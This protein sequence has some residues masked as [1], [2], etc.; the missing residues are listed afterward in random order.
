MRG[1]G[2]E[3]IIEDMEVDKEST[4]SEGVRLPKVRWQYQRLLRF[5]FGLVVAL[6]AFSM[7]Q[8]HRIQST[9]SNE[10]LEIYHRH[11]RQD[12]LLTRLRRTLWLG[13]NGTRDY[14]VYPKSGAEP[15]RRVIAG[16]KA[17]SH[18]ILEQLGVSAPPRE[19]KPELKQEV[20][21]FW[22]ALEAVP[23]TTASFDPAARYDFIQREIVPRRNAVG[24]L[25]REFTE[26]SE[27]T[28]KESEAEFAGT[29][30]QFGRELL[31]VLGLCLA[32]GSVV[33]I[34]SVAHAESLERKNR[35]HYEQMEQAKTELQEL[36]SRL[37]EVQEEER[38]RLS[39][40]LHDEV[41]QMVATVRLELS[42]AGSLPDDRLPE[43]RQRIDSAREL[44]GRTL[45]IV[46]D[47]CLL[48]RPTVLDDLGLGAA[49]HW[50]AEEFS[51][52]TGIECE[53][54]E[55]GLS[56]SLPD[57]L[58]T[59]VYRVLQEALHNCE[60]HAGA[61]KVRVAVRQFAERVEMEVEDNGR[62]F[63]ADSRKPQPR[64]SR[65][66]LLGMRERAAGLGGALEI[67]SAPG[68]GTTIRLSVALPAAGS[69]ASPA[70]AGV[71]V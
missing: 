37:M 8:A 69:A 29:R 15:F 19:F 32:T 13:A 63:D 31:L 14:L 51:R 28:L 20:D 59:C 33:S 4:D 61:S 47:I 66:G 40:E 52:R 58:K 39:R 64:G 6:L 56:E 16:L 53:F 26:L 70:A 50:Q 7:F 21:A 23:K 45:H 55:N 17:E 49:L 12:D 5:G 54:C 11:L 71:S 10:A 44:A 22:S 60:K 18:R 36:S 30:R 27:K 43:M 38:V 68:K 2:R 9:L 57:Q 1:I 42:R 41:G 67:R 48:L 62:G 46:R 25:V 65:F 35:L 3:E 34:V 24:N